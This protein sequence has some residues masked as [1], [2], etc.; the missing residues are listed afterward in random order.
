M[1]RGPCSNNELAEY[2]RLAMYT[3]RQ[4]VLCYLAELERRAGRWQIAADY[5]AEAMETVVESGRTAT[6]SHVVLFNQAGAAAHLGQVDI[7]R[8]QA[9][10][11]VRPALANDDSFNAN[12]N[13]A[14][15]GFL[16]LSPVE[17]RAGAR[18]PSTGRGV[19]RTDGLGGAGH[20]PLYPR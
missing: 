3:V 18:P 4:E 5:A 15:L 2:E 16:E 19:S 14:V 11:G 20:H 7:A 9:T 12:W 17:P 6:Q 13:R 8:S 10:E 1:P